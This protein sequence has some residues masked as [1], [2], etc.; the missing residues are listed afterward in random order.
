MFVGGCA[1]VKVPMEWATEGPAAAGGSSGSGAA[2]RG[3]AL[4]SDTA[5]GG[6]AVEAFDNIVCQI[7]RCNS[8]AVLPLGQ[9]AFMAKLGF[10][11]LNNLGLESY[12]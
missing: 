8:N 11:I 5:C 6:A 2:L 12:K 9:R 1:Q 4:G 10:N 3:R 7:G